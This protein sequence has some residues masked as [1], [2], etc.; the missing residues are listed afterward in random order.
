MPSKV[1]P[2]SG[3]IQIQLLNLLHDQ[4]NTYFP[5][6]LPISL[7]VAFVDVTFVVVIVI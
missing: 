4:M 5:I 6:L 1:T 7:D 3:N 2:S